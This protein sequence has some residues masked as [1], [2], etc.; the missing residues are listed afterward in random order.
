MMKDEY[1]PLK[2]QD[3]IQ[4]DH[5]GIFTYKFCFK[6]EVVSRKR[7]HSNSS[8]DNVGG[9]IQDAKDKFD[10]T[11]TIEMENMVKKLNTAKQIQTD[12]INEKISLEKSL[13]EKIVNLESF[14]GQKIQDL[15]GREDE[16]EREKNV[17]VKQ[18]IEEKHQI[19]TRMK[20]DIQR[21]EVIF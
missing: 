19:E 18:S 21:F 8:C 2:D 1:V 16:I 14:Y 10:S 4:F 9:R 11:Q 3:I 20:E 17:L 5:G 13:Q 7:K 12:I 15:K 6:N